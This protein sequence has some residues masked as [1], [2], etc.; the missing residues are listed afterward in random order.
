MP[1]TLEGRASRGMRAALIGGY[2]LTAGEFFY[3]AS[4]FA[5]YFYG[6]YRP[7]LAT[8]LRVPF[9]A[10]LARF[11]LP[12]YVV[13][14]S[15][16]FVRIHETVGLALV[17]V[18]L[19]G[20][21]C[22]AGPVYW[23]KLTRSGPVT[24]GVYRVVRHP[25]Y[26][27][28][29]VAGLGLLL[30]WPRFLA[31]V[32]FVSMLFVY[33]GLAWVEERKCERAFG[34]RYHEYRLR[35]GMFW[36]GSEGKTLRLGGI[37]LVGLYV[38]TLAVA[39]GVGK[40]MAAKTVDGLEVRYTRD[41]AY[42]AVANMD[43]GALSR[44]VTLAGA[45][46]DLQGQIATGGT[47]AARFINYVLPAD[48]W[49]PEIPMRAPAG[50]DCHRTPK[51]SDSTHYHVV[52]TRAELGCDASCRGRDILLRTTTRTGVAEAWFDLAAG[53]LERWSAGVSDPAYSGTPVP[54][55]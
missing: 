3:M 15:S 11:F 36:P 32:L 48:W 38:V 46:P 54:V 26:V 4:P 39:L 8:L 17:G 41:A 34:R 27:A 42:V 13:A 12:H 37:G 23:A 31:L 30:L 7:G 24:G 35:T 47:G 5:G 40:W 29:A 43:P 51:T 49:I 55:L 19:C 2:L 14:S 6:A 53:R 45:A 22:G 9:G 18:G 44:V 50:A 20:F 1:I 52:F 33:L 10:W 28:L 21:A 25:Q 16:L